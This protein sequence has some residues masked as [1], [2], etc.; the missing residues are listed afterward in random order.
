MKRYWVVV[1]DKTSHGGLVVEGSL[2]DEVEGKPI[3]TLMCKVMCPAHGTTFIASGADLFTVMTNGQ[4]VALDGAVTACGATVYAQLQRL[5]YSDVGSGSAPAEN[6]PA[7]DAIA[8]ALEA[9]EA[10]GVADL[11]FRHVTAY[12]EPIARMPVKVTLA[13]GSIEEGV[14]D[15]AG[16]IKFADVPAGEA[17]VEYGESQATPKATTQMEADE[18]FLKIISLR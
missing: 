18:D 7:A 15:S 3:A 11:E 5:A 9:A 16:W 4:P 13:D 10:A 8:T 12:G 17:T 14:T 1:G 6:L 2:F